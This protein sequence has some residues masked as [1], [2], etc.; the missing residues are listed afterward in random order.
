MGED[1]EENKG[2]GKCIETAYVS[3]RLAFYFV[4]VGLIRKQ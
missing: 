1:E 4:F 3:G 2:N